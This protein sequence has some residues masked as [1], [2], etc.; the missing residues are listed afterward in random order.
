MKVGFTGT[1]HGM[2]HEQQVKFVTTFN[3]LL[4][5][6]ELHHGDCVGADHQAHRQ[7][8]MCGIRVVIHPPDSVAKRALCRGYSEIRPPL[9]YLER[10]HNIV[11]ETELLI[12]TPGTMIEV[13]RSGT[14]ATVRYARKLR[15]KIIIIW[16]NGRIT[17]ENCNV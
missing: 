8:I 3:G 12:A 7:A 15:R 9:P 10:N 16:P 4:K 5:L 6:Q 1:Q 14:W 11:N 13:P 17:K 2:T